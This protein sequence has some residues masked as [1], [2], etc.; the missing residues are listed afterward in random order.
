MGGAVGRG[1]S[2]CWSWQLEAVMDQRSCEL[3][4][5]EGSAGEKHCLSGRAGR[6]ESGLGSGEGGLGA[7]T[8]EKT[9]GGW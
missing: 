2:L 5:S 8:E 7:T 1:P 3:L 9:T 6:L 4:W